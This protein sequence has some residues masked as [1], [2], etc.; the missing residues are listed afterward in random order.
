MQE[1]F[2]IEQELRKAKAELEDQVYGLQI[3]V[4]EEKQRAKKLANRVKDEE[5]VKHKYF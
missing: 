4:E 1:M 5:S 3:Q 2:R